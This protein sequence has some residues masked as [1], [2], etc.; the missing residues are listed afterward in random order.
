MTRRYYMFVLCNTD[1][2]SA[3]ISSCSNRLLI[4]P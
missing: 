3:V 2:V 1:Q 4:K